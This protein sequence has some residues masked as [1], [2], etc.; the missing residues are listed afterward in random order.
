MNVNNFCKMLTANIQDSLRDICLFWVLLGVLNPANGPVFREFY[1]DICQTED[2]QLQNLKNLRLL[3]RG[4]QPVLALAMRM[5]LTHRKLIRSTLVHRRITNS[6][7]LLM[8]LIVPLVIITYHN[9]EWIHQLIWTKP[10]DLCQKLPWTMLRLARMISRC[11]AY[12]C[13][14]TT[15]I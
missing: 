14:N 9:M 6:S 12:P 7:A 11:P 2:F 5:A 3:L 13:P 15:T 4:Q 1:R 8:H 10:M